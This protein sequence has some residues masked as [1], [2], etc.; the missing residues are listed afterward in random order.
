MSSPTSPFRQGTDR[1]YQRVSVGTHHIRVFMAGSNLNAQGLPN[2]PAIVSTV[3][4]DTTFTFA[5]GVH[6][7]FLWQGAVES[8][9]A[10]VRDYH[11]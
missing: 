11:G 4:G 7:T 6:Y 5:E 9:R 2:D 10:E 3:L 1:A 8:W